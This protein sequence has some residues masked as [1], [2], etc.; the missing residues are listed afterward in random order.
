MCNCQCVLGLYGKSLIADMDARFKYV[1]PITLFYS[2]TSPRKDEVSKL[3][4]DFYFENSTINDDTVASVV[5]VSRSSRLYI[6]NILHNVYF[7][8]TPF[9]M[10]LEHAY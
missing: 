10:R 3:I 1:A 8:N 2:E 5:N 6:G 9:H 4:R 7:L